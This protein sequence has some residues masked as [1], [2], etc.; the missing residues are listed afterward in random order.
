MP[1][2]AN[3]ACGGRF[4]SG[5]CAPPRTSHRRVLRASVPS[6]MQTGRT[7]ARPAFRRFGVA[8]GTPVFGEHRI[9]VRGVR[10]QCGRQRVGQGMPA[11]A[12]IAKTPSALA[13]GLAQLAFGPNR[14]PGR[15][16]C[17]LTQAHPGHPDPSLLFRMALSGSPVA[18]VQPRT[19]PSGSPRSAAA[20]LHSYLG[21]PSCLGATS[22]KRLLVDQIRSCCLAWRL[23]AAQSTPCNVAHG[24]R[25]APVACMR[26]RTGS[27]CPVHPR[28]ARFPAPSASGCVRPPR[29]SARP[30]RVSRPPPLRTHVPTLSGNAC[31]GPSQ[32]RVGGGP[33]GPG[34]LVGNPTRPT[35][36]SAYCPR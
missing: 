36:P 8:F 26:S 4:T 31:G 15:R 16:R 19:T 11:F 6:R 21:P 9:V 17:N 23:L 3:A 5:G 27:P 32:A 20:A 33:A 12:S 35:A 14:I 18:S 22:H 24:Q 30:C 1:A 29:V 13:D 7:G 10:S 34:L 25:S 28:K 2:H